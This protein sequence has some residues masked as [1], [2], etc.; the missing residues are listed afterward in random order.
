MFVDTA[1]RCPMIETL[2][3]EGARGPWLAILQ[4]VLELAGPLAQFVHHAERPWS[5][6]TYSGATHR[7]RLSFAGAE[8]VANGEGFIAALPD[9]EFALPGRLV[10]KATIASAEHGL[11]DGPLLTIEAELLVLDEA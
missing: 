11:V 5:S 3:R 10:A 9:H 2:R 1:S 8:A 6:T 4:Q 7:F